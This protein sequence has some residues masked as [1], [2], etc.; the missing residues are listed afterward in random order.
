MLLFDEISQRLEARQPSPPLFPTDVYDA[1]ISRRLLSPDEELAAHPALRCGLLLWND[2]LEASHEIAQSL[3]NA[4]GAFWHAIMHRREGD[5]ANANYWWRRTGTHPAFADVLKAA[6]STLKDQTEAA[7]CAFA[8]KLTQSGA[9]NPIDFVAAVE[10][11]KRNGEDD[12][13]LRRV[14]VAEMRALL[15][16]CRANP[17]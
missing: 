2:D 3:D 12:E 14:Q 1:D 8:A 11:T 7:A 15:T 17:D 9:W 6:Q 4:T 10:R 13:W 5:G 16:W